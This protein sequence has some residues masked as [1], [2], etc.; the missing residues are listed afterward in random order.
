MIINVSGD[1]TLADA[2]DAA[3]Y[4]QELAGDD[5]NIIFGAMY[6][7][8]KGDSCSITVIA[9]GLE[10]ETL[11][12]NKP[13]SQFGTFANKYVKPVTPNLNIRSNNMGQGNM[14]GAN[15]S[16]RPN[17]VPVHTAPTRPLTGMTSPGDLRSN[18]ADKPLKIPEFLQKK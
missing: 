15:M 10:D 16:G 11:P 5:V 3:S 18:I 1:I 9:T 17:A 14:E 8:S 4:V 13:V 7:E 12:T 2:S 6:D